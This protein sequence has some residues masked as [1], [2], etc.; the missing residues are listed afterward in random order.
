MERRLRINV[1]GGGIGWRLCCSLP[2]PL[3]SISWCSGVRLPAMAPSSGRLLL[4]IPRP[5]GQ[6]LAHV[7]QDWHSYLVCTSPTQGLQ[8]LGFQT[9]LWRSCPPRKSGEGRGLKKGEGKLSRGLM[10]ASACEEAQSVPH[11]ATACINLSVPQG[12][13]FGVTACKVHVMCSKSR[14]Q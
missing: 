8:A 2:P 4:S 10:W 11:Q 1:A 7:L 5:P 6:P 14:P 12:F 3:P 13:L 9:S